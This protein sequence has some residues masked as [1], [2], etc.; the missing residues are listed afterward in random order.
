MKKLVSLIL[1][2]AVLA[3]FSLGCGGMVNKDTKVKCPKCGAVFTIDEGLK[4][5]GP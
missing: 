5:I 4:T 1:A 2:L 3:V